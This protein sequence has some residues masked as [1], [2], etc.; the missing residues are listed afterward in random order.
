[1]RI[2][3]LDHIVLTVVDISAT[4]AFYSRVLG[5]QEITFGDQ[6]KALAFGQQKINLHPAGRPIAPHAASPTPGSA[7][8]CFIVTGG[9]QE[10]LAHLQTCGVA[11]EAGPVPRTGATGPIISVYFRDPDG[12]L[13]EVATY[14]HLGH[15]S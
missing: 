7:D 2:D 5:M 1:M 4:I 10:V 11:L 3:H 8:L 14:D 15:G 9:I 13:L 12:N 6:R